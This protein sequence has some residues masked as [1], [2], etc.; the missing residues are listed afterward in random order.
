MSLI[1]RIPRTFTQAWQPV[2]APGLHSCASIDIFTLALQPPSPAMKALSS[3]TDDIDPATVV[4]SIVLND[5]QLSLLAELDSDPACVFARLRR[6]HA[7]ETRLPESISKTDLYLLL[8]DMMMVFGQHVAERGAVDVHVLIEA[9]IVEA[10]TAII[11]SRD[12]FLRPVEWRSTIVSIL[13]IVLQEPM[14]IDPAARGRICRTATSLFKSIWDNRDVVRLTDHDRGVGNLPD[15]F[16]QSLPTL[17]KA[18]YALHGDQDIVPGMDTY[19]HHAHLLLWILAYEEGVQ[20]HALQTYAMLYD[21]LLMGPDYDENL[22]KALKQSAKPK[23]AYL[24]VK[25]SC[26]KVRESFIQECI[27]EG[28]GADRF[29][30]AC[31]AALQYTLTHVG[32]DCANSECGCDEIAGDMILLGHYFVTS[33]ALMPTVYRRD[34]LASAL[35]ALKPLL[36]L[37]FGSPKCIRICVFCLYLVPY[38]HLYSEGASMRTAS[39]HM[40]PDIIDVFI[41]AVQ[42]VAGGCITRSVEEGS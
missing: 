40:Y 10:I 17:V 30:A 38:Y 31:E 36:V 22:Q 37:E 4:A 35:N 6:L 32:S 16:G 14:T 18:Y 15:P 8:E 26:W 27:V 20:G 9:G 3:T 34:L 2:F 24:A 29:V 23:A 41:G 19:I 12:F 42:L 1:L 28:I 21:A 33:E 7:E 5:R 13:F 25:G 11:A 39:P